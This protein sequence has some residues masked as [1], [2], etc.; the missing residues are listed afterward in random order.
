MFHD[1]FNAC[2]FIAYVWKQAIL[3]IKSFNNEIAWN[4]DYRTSRAVAYT[5][6][7]ES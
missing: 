2:K 6:I 1:Q 4:N 7:M 5:N 3:G